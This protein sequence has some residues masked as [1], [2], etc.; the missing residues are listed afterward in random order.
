MKR[1]VVGVRR[2]ETPE[3]P[4]SRQY[5][6]TVWFPSIATMVAALSE[7]NRAMLRLIQKRKPKPLTEL[8]GECLTC[9]A[10]CG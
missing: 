2:V 3:A 7:D 1:R 8:G 9:H 5:V 6:P 4:G 10:R